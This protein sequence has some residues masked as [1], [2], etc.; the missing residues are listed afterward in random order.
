MSEATA[1]L[2]V[3]ATRTLN[4]SS[5]N[6]N[7]N[8]NNNNNDNNNE[9]NK[10]KKQEFKG[11]FGCCQWFITGNY[12]VKKKLVFIGWIII[13]CMSPIF[14]GIYLNSTD[15]MINYGF[16]LCC[17]LAILMSLYATFNFRDVI[18]LREAVNMLV[19][20]TQEL[21]H[22]RDKIRSEVGKLQTAHTKLENIEEKLTESNGALRKNFK[23]LE[24]WNKTIREETKLHQ[25][26]AT[27]IKK[28][29]KSAII[30]YQKLL[31][32]NEKAI[33]DKA[34]RQIEGKDGKK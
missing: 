11:I 2:E 5:S 10:N 28:D 13:G 16:I 3:A 22:Q 21:A 6:L 17:C 31:V 27:Q 20:N 8:T 18:S 7:D 19:E 29:F 30:Q 23:K 32:Q 24:T 1:L 9:N 25:E 15:S 12:C 4:N 33:L 14:Y 34:Y 26:N